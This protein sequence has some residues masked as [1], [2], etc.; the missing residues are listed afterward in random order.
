[1]SLAAQAERRSGSS[2]SESERYE[3]CELPPGQ[4]LR[5]A[6]VLAA[7][8]T[9]AGARLGVRTLREEGEAEPG[10]LVIRDAV[11]GRLLPG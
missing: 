8:G 1:M 10:R 2:V 9:L 4:E 3:I 5:H 7:A 11:T 6:R